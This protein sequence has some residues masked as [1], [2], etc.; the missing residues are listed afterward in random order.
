MIKFELVIFFLFNEREMQSSLNLLTCLI[1]PYF[2]MENFN[3][4]F[5]PHIKPLTFIILLI[6][7][8]ENIISISI[9]KANIRERRGNKLSGVFYFLFYVS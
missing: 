2:F 5:I 9:T 6:K 8:Q 3:R 1:K 7:V 4:I